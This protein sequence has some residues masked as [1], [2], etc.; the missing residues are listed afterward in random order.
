[1]K[2]VVKLIRYGIYLPL[3]IA[4][5]IITAIEFLNMFLQLIGIN[6]LKNVSKLID[7]DSLTP[8]LGFQNG[9]TPFSSWVNFKLWLAMAVLSGSFILPF[10]V[11]SLD[12]QVESKSEPDLARI[13]AR[14]GRILTII[15]NATKI[16]VLVFVGLI[17]FNIISVPLSPYLRWPLLTAIGV[18]L[19]IDNLG[20]SRR[21]HQYGL[22]NYFDGFEKLLPKAVT[23]FTGKTSFEEEY[24]KV[25]EKNKK[26][27]DRE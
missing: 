15:A 17:Y 19:A 10:I 24:K 9:I 8:I 12:E 16:T 2:T 27:I 11:S 4:L 18:I 3:E 22:E 20:W 25:I 13:R 6:V 14:T 23:K 21:R 7:I 5:L 26:E 1:M